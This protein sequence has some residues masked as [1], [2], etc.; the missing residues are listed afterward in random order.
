M[1]THMG[2]PKDKEHYNQWRK[3]ET[4]GKLGTHMEIYKIMWKCKKTAEN[5]RK[6][7]KI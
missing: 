5:I 7:R 4:F 3:L 6:S 1:D 2:K